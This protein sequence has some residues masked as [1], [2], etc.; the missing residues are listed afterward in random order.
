VKLSRH[1]ARNRAF[2][3]ELADRYQA[4]QGPQLAI[5]GAAWGV[6]QIPESELRILGDVAG[7]DTL[8]LGCGAA[9]WSIA[10]ARRGAHATGLDLSERQLEHA[11]RAVKAAGFDV[12]LLHASAEAIPL[13]AAS[14]DIVFC[15]HGAIGFTDPERAIP[16]AARVLRPGGLLA[17]SMYTPLA[18]ACWPAT[19]EEPVARLENRYFGMRRV[20][21][22][23]SAHVEFQLTY[24]DWVRL[25]V[26][27]GLVIEDLVEL[28]PAADATS[29][30]RSAGARDWARRW[31][32][33]HVWRLRRR[34]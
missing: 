20:D 15:D 21:V 33:E 9:Q 5:H 25:F 4:E 32:L 7:R 27:A 30:Y 8:E 11:R 26:R 28:R 19:S 12:S 29:T 34:P 14:F 3:N 23:D 18:E 10:L 17:F 13:P 16:E 6:W 22:G 2:W 1:A 31:P 24:G